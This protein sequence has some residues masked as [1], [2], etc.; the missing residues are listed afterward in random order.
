MSFFGKRCVITVTL[1]IM[2]VVMTGCNVVDSTVLFLKRSISSE[3]EALLS[4]DYGER[5]YY[6]QL[7]EEERRDYRLLLSAYLRMDKKVFG[8]EMS[9]SDILRLNKLI[10][11]DCPE[12]FWVVNS[13]VY[14]SELETLVFDIGVTYE[15][16]Y[17]YTRSQAIELMA[18][19]DSVCA[20]LIAD[21]SDAD[22]Y[23]KALAAYDFIISGTVY[24]DQKAQ[25]ILSDGDYDP[26][27][28]TSQC[29][30]SVLLEGKSVCAGYSS[31]YQYLLSKLG[32]FSVAVIGTVN[33]EGA[34]ESY[35]HQWNLLELDGEYY[36][37]DITWG[38][39]ENADGDTEYTYFCITDRE[40]AF[41]HTPKEWAKYPKAD[42]VECNYFYRIGAYCE[43]LD[44]LFIGEKIL[45]A[46]SQKQESITLKFASY[47][48]Y[49]DFCEVLETGQGEAA[50]LN[51]ILKRISDTYEYFDILNTAYSVS[52]QLCVVRI[53]FSYK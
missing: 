32:V 39:P 25:L 13:G 11:L 5:F 10:L 37:T 19:I 20:P 40:M 50:F 42:A 6:S 49:T 51:I 41:T 16:R 12:L 43:T 8:L 27:T 46:V 38:E 14:Y 26:V 18:Q 15:P 45:S 30:I 48:D 2:L 28:D 31:A 17:R 4:I 21:Y 34:E 7:S 1:L 24:D 36:Y 53:H 22:D 52:D 29:I 3:N 47:A 35:N 44:T 23:E 33:E 9:G